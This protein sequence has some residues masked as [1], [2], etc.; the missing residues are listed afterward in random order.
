MMAQLLAPRLRGS[1]GFT[2]IEMMIV[3]SIIAILSTVAVPAYVDRVVQAQVKDALNLAEVAQRAV[4]A[5]YS[6]KGR[7]PKDNLEAGLPAADKFIGNYVTAVAIADG[8]VT[9]T[10]G[11]RVNAFADGKLLSMRP[12]IVTG[13]RVVPIAWVC[14]NASVPKGMTVAGANRTTLPPPQLPLDCRL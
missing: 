12:A 8:V 6:Q 1:P 13:A 2:L 14:G 5:F 10:L 4:D 7:L 3:V 9:V 11:N